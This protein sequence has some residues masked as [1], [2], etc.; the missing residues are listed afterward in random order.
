M[1]VPFQEPSTSWV[2]ERFDSQIPVLERMTSTGHTVLEPKHRAANLAQQVSK[3]DWKLRQIVETV[4]MKAVR[5]PG[6]LRIGIDAMKVEARS[7]CICLETDA[8]RRATPTK[9]LISKGNDPLLW[10]GLFNQNNM[11]FL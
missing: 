8:L 7:V 9:N 10:K 11:P 2:L 3:L 4:L 6:Q 1:S 5:Q